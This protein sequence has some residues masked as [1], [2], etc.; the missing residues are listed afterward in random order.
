MIS[1]TRSFVPMAGAAV[2]LLASLN[3][4]AQAARGRGDMCA[5]RS[6]AHDAETL[7]AERTGVFAKPRVRPLLLSSPQDA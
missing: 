2:A 7:A 3:V 6:G 4:H 1:I 5:D